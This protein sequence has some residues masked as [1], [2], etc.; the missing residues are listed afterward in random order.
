MSG[1]RRTLFSQ[2][3]IRDDLEALNDTSADQFKLVMAMVKGNCDREAVMLAYRAGYKSAL[4]GMAKM[5]GIGV[6]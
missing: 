5:C 6:A 4:S 3:E 1:V 2:K